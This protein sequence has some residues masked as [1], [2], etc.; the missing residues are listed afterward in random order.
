MITSRLLGQYDSETTAYTPCGGA[1]QTSPYAPDFTG[2]LKG[3]K[4]MAGRNAV[5]TLTDHIQVRLTSTTFVP[6]SLE[7]GITGGGLQTAPVGAVVKEEWPCN[8]RVQAGVPIIVEGRNLTA[9]TP[10]TNNLL[11]YGIFE[12]GGR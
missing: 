10:V 8:Q 9:D 2:I 4:L 12:V 11:I 6:N 5:T 3:I 1:A 7:V